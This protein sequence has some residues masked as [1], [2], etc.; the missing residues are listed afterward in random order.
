[1]FLLAPPSDSRIRRILQ[2]QVHAPFTYP[3]VG[4]T[5]YGTAPRGYI[6]NHQ[7]FELGTGLATFEQAKAAVR[8]WRMFEL[9]WV[10]VFWPDAPIQPSALVAV[11]AR[12]VGWWS[13][14]VCRIVYVIDEE[15]RYGFGYGTLPEHA[16]A[17]EERFTVEWL[18]DDSV[19]YDILA[20]SR[21]KHPLARLAYPLSRRLQDKFRRDSGLALK[22][23]VGTL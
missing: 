9:G 18:D 20:F 21:E 8:Q 6:L 19:W 4:S 3:E 15:R 1:M 10:R 11:L 17:G 22:R 5:A 12:V 16:E 23:A 2:S 14:N 13:L 7:R